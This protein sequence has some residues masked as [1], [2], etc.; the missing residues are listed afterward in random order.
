MF[1][2]SSLLIVMLFSIITVQFIVIV[3]QYNIYKLLKKRYSKIEVRIKRHIEKFIQTKELLDYS[4]V[5][6]KRLEKEQN[7]LLWK[8]EN[9]SYK[10]KELEC[11]LSRDI[12]MPPTVSFKE[13]MLNEFSDNYDVEGSYPKNSIL[14]KVVRLQ[15]ITRNVLQHCRFERMKS[16]Q[17][18]LNPSVTVIKEMTTEPSSFKP[19]LHFK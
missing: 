9:I 12:G 16:T 8:I 4:A 19:S 14:E 7:H 10:L 15:E 11:L 1:I 18:Y 5:E 6:K 3:K 17:H 2:N 13:C